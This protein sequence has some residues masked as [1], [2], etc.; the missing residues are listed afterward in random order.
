MEGTCCCVFP[1]VRAAFEDKKNISNFGKECNQYN[2][3]EFQ[4]LP[5]NNKSQDQHFLFLELLS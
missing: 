2:Q 5:S 3:M 4:L 1:I